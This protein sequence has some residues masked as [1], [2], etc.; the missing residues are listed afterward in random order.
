MTRARGDAGVGLG[1]QPQVVGGAGDR[2]VAQATMPL[3]LSRNTPRAGWSQSGPGRPSRSA[4]LLRCHPSTPDRPALRCGP[5]PNIG[6]GRLGQ[7]EVA[8]QDPG[9]V[10]DR[11]GLL[12]IRKQVGPRPNP[13][14]GTS[15]P[16]RRTRSG[17][18]CPGSVHWPNAPGEAAHT[19]PTRAWAR[20]QLRADPRPP[21]SNSHD[22]HR[23]AHSWPL[24][25]SFS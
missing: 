25:G 19:A 22:R 16:L 21:P 12:V 11:D 18:V 8:D 3:D 9:D 17:R 7:L 6:G 24:L 14:G 20:I 5:R 23:G 10:L 2:R 1:G 15:H 4:R 13:G